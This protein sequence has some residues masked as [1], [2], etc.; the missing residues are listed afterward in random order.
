MPQIDRHKNRQVDIEFS[1]H[2]HLDLNT[3]KKRYIII[4]ISQGSGSI[5]LNNYPLAIKDHHV[6][7]LKSTDTL[8]II[9]QK[10]LVLSSFSFDKT[11]LNT[12]RL[13][14]TKDVQ[15]PNTPRIKEGLS[16]FEN[17]SQH[18]GLIALDSQVYPKFLQWFF[19]LG[20]EVHVQS[21][22]LWVCRIKQYLIQI[23]NLLKELELDQQNSAI[24]MALQYIHLNYTSPIRLEDLTNLTHLNRVSLNEQFKERVNQ[25]AL[26]YLLS[27]RLNIAEQMLTH[28]GMTL[29]DIAMSTGFEYDTYFMKQF[30]QHQGMSPTEYRKI[31]RK[32]ASVQ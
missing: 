29:N 10:N 30:K 28:T 14:Q 7:C 21:D 6:I 17:N 8:E 3:P 18:H 22:D 20:M 19:T 16:L 11:F 1:T 4:L 15:V 12:V 23:F 2:Q 31:T 27:Y 32:I 9:E 5:K 24:E 13:S 26:Q 25:T